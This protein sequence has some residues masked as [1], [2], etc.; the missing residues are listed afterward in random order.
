MEGLALAEGF[1]REIRIFQLGKESG[2]QLGDTVDSA[3]PPLGHKGWQALPATPA[4]LLRHMSNH[5]T[6]W[7]DMYN[8]QKARDIPASPLPLQPMRWSAQR[9]PGSAAT[10]HHCCSDLPSPTSLDEYTALPLPWETRVYAQ[11]PR[12]DSRSLVKRQPHSPG[13]SHHRQGDGQANAQVAPHEGG[14]LREEPGEEE[15]P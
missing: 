2:M 12:R 4:E 9:S 1:N 6:A 14:S 10:Q 3:C 11:L 7:S 8:F 15:M 5:C 13:S